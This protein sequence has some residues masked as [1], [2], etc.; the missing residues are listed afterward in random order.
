MNFKNKNVII[1]GGTSGIGLAT[2]K[3][4][5]NAEATVWITGRDQG[6]LD[7]AAKVIN[8]EKLK[9]I[10]ADTSTS[11]G[12][13][14]LENTLSTLESKIDVLFL[15]AGI[16]SFSTIEFATEEQFEAQFNTNV[17]GPYFTLQKA[18][19]FLNEGSSVIFTSSTN[20]TMRNVGSSI[21]SATKG[22]LNKVA[23]IAANELS[24]RKIRVNIL[25]PGPTDTE[26]LTNA[27]PKE[28]KDYLKS[29]TLSKRLGEPIEIANAVLF[30]SSEN[31]AFINGTEFIVDG[32]MI[33]NAMK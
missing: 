19:P 12:I 3:A 29:I 24:D 13:E 17:K 11:S 7:D 14:A 23:E 6:R 25:S 22:A 21:Y 18:I 8:N 10:L 4:F 1:T 27:I 28:A 30:L 16:A 2:A 5:L 20:A 31:A 26:G 15:N 9:T 32:G 33:N